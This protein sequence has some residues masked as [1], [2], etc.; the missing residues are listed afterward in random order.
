MRAAGEIRGARRHCDEPQEGG[1]DC[2]E[3]GG[4]AD[5]SVAAGAAGR[6]GVIHDGF[7][8]SLIRRLFED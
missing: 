4:N 3:Y 7:V 6:R 5:Q 8:P 1:K 2:D